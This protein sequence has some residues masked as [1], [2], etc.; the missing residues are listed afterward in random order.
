MSSDFIIFCVVTKIYVFIIIL[1][2]N[3]TI[4]Q[5]KAILNFQLA[6]SHSS[7]FCCRNSI[8]YLL[9]LNY[10][11]DKYILMPTLDMADNTVQLCF[12]RYKTWIR[13]VECVVYDAFVAKESE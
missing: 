1:L 7:K 4:R 6:S 9:L 11:I 8:P 10:S 2:I 13:T 3:C 5:F 12:G